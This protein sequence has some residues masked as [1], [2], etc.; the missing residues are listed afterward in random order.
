MNRILSFGTVVLVIATTLAAD[1]GANGLKRMYV[2]DCGRLV[3]KDQSRWTPGV[4]VGQP[5][6]L[7]NTAISSSMSAACCCG[8]QACPTRSSIKRAG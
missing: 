8:I 7:S 2:L 4:N 1:P 6:E 3:A 5:R